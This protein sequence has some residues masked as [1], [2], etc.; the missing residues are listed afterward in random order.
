MDVVQA[1]E[2]VNM[3]LPRVLE[4]LRLLVSEGSHVIPPS[5]ADSGLYVQCRELTARADVVD[6]IRHKAGTPATVSS[7]WRTENIAC[8]GSSVD[9]RCSCPVGARGGGIV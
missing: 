9:E 4:N 6:I 8:W 5:A 1:R 3:N 7:V 2:V